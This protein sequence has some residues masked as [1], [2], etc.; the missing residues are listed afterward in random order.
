MLLASVDSNKSATI[1]TFVS[2][3]FV[4]PFAG[5]FRAKYLQ[6]KRKKLTNKTVSIIS[7]DC[8]GGIIYH[9]MNLRFLSPTVNLFFE[10]DNDFLEY[11]S[12]I[13]HYS[14]Q[15]PQ[16]VKRDGKNYPIGEIKKNN[17]GIIIHFLHYKSLEEAAN[18]WIERGKRINYNNL[19]IIWHNG[20]VSGPDKESFERF[21]TIPQQKLLITGSNFNYNDENVVKL[22]LYGKNYF[23]GKILIRKSKYSAKRFLDEVDYVSWL[24]RCNDFGNSNN[25]G[26]K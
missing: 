4:Q 9:D 13:R 11:L 14:E 17:S 18:K 12:D 15:V 2:K 26:G 7:N 3:A 8:V 6:R 23:P 22:K 21:Q 1:R 10:T 19:F 25:T 24:N 16:P 5:H 20:S